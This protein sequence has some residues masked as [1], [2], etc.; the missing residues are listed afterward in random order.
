MNYPQYP[1]RKDTNGQAI[2]SMVLGIL[3]LI[4][5]YIGFILGI[6]AIVLSRRASREIQ[7]TGQNGKGFATAGLVCGIIGTA[8]YA[9]VIVFALLV[10]LFA[11]STYNM[12]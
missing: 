7:Y 1:E 5:P 9:V 12:Y 3:S 11:F 6:I 2:A 8:I 10:G 4:I